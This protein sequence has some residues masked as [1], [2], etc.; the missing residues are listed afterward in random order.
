MTFI[1][2]I[3]ILLLGLLSNLTSTPQSASQQNNKD[4]ITKNE[5]NTIFTSLE[6]HFNDNG[7]YP[8]S[9]QF[10]NDWETE[11][12]GISSDTVYN[13]DGNIYSYIPDSC[14]AVGCQHYKLS[15]YLSD[16]TLYEKVSL[17]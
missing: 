10:Y 7:N 11:L 12:P 14:S 1:F 16:G 4:I 15:S 6:V 13:E 2:T 8:T 3:L 5:I 9:S 17:N